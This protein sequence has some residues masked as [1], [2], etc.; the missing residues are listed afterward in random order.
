MLLSQREGSCVSTTECFFAGTPVAM[1][2][3]AHVGSRAYINERTGILLSRR[4]MARALGRF[5]DESERFSPR[6][7][8]EANVFTHAAP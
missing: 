3:D 1:M 7:W 5:L 8:A 4:G 6:E 2:R